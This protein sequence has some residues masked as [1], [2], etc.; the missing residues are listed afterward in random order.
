MLRHIL[1]FVFAFLLCLA[2]SWTMGDQA[3]AI[4]EEQMEEINESMP[5]YVPPTTMPAT[6]LVPEVRNCP[7]ARQ[8][9]V[10]G[11]LITYCEDDHGN[12]VPQQQ[13]PKTTP[14][15]ASAHYNSSNTESSSSIYA[16][17]LPSALLLVVACCLS[18]R[19]I[20]RRPHQ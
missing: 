3:D 5:Y 7:E 8:D 19:M 11:E 17:L 12:L 20:L 13:T 15:R 18:L 10:S 14:K 6:T 4:N 2:F 9:P 1:K 16:R